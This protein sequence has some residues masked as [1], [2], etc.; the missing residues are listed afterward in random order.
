MSVDS[1]AY[2]EQR[3]RE[4]HL[5]AHLDRFRALG[6]TSLGSLA[7][8]SDFV[9][10][11][12]D[13]AIFARE[14][15]VPAL[16]S[17]DHADK[18]LLRRLY[19]EAYSLATF[20]LRRRCESTED[21]AP[22]RLPPAERNSRRKRIANRL[23]G[24][25]LEG[26]LDPSHRLQDL[27][28]EI[29]DT[30]TVKYISLE[31][32]TKRESELQGTKTNTEWRVDS[33]GFLKQ[34]TEREPSRADLRSDLLL[35]C[36]LRRRAIAF[37]MADLASYETME[38]VTDLYLRRLMATPLPG[39]SKVSLDQ[40]VRADMELFNQLSSLCLGAVKRAPDGRRPF[41][42]HIP[43]ITDSI[44]FRYLLAP[45]P[46][47]A[48][49]GKSQQFDDANLGDSKRRSLE[50]SVKDLREENKRLRTKG[51]QTPASSY[52]HQQSSGGGGKGS[53]GKGK[54]K[55][56][57][58]SPKVPP[59]LVGKSFQTSHGEPI[60]FAYNLPGGCTQAAPG[61]RCQRGLHV[62]AEPGCTAH[63]S[64]QKHG[65]ESSS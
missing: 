48:S 59:G 3:V 58:H 49:S 52:S 54:G 33:S 53:K 32:A 31:H 1:N 51:P 23:P 7:Y 18:H 44:D 57:N 60:C 63:H 29:W 41:D 11:V 65:S 21:D 26:E 39:F 36:A 47:N 34:S 19:V 38:A 42:V 62:C 37:E 17:E 10:G 25:C 50:Q 55:S 28:F 2:F 16:G 64:L 4:L 15:A 6:W 40:V 8:A 56:K 22:R 5:D 9:P 14:V 61:R 46:G 43:T 30:D 45:L 24:L 27:A 20:E 35:Q 12:S 13:G